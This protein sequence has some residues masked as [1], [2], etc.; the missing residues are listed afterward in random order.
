M[1]VPEY[2]EMSLEDAVELMNSRGLV[3]FEKCTVVADAVSGKIVSVI[4]SSPASMAMAAV[5]DNGLVLTLLESPNGG[6]IH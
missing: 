5:E 3:A 2:A 4:P 6:L 1:D